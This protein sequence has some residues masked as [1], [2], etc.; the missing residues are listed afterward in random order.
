MG[1]GPVYE[2][3]SGFRTLL[4]KYEEYSVDR[5]TWTMQ[6]LSLCESVFRTEPIAQTFLYLCQNGAITAWLLQVQLDIPEATAYR[7]LKR[8]RTLQLI[9]P[10][11][12]LPKRKLKK[13]GPTPTVW[14][15]V[16]NWAD[17][18]VA[19]CIN[20]HY[21]SL[22][23]KYRLAEEIAQDILDNYIKKRGINEVSYREIFIH[24]KERRIPFMTADIANLTARYLHEQ[25]VKV[26]R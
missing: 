21:R 13:S 25:G 17:D 7:V 22:S 10:I 2:V 24:I 19:R 14:G 4:T 15:L 3:V 18:D 6:I 5:L 8:M 1:E 20:L 23:P 16:G 26:W 12:K 11:L 9:E